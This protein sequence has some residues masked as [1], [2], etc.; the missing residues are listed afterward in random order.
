ME[1]RKYKTLEGLIRQTNCKQI[2][3]EDFFSGEF[4]HRSAGWCG[5]VLPAKEKRHAPRKCLQST[6]LLP[7]ARAVAWLTHFARGAEIFPFC[8]VLFSLYRKAGGCTS[9]QR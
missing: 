7:S 3:A 2:T 5:F 1:T 6:F 9:A 8:R 4:Y